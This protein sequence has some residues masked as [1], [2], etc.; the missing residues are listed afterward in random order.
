MMERPAI[1]EIEKHDGSYRVE[2]R[3]RETGRS[4][5]SRTLGNVEAPETTY[6]HVCKVR[7]P[8]GGKPTIDVEPDDRGARIVLRTPDRTC[9]RHSLPTHTAAN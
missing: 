4:L 7:L 1:I 5:G 8:A 9:Y 3:E 2:L 6:K